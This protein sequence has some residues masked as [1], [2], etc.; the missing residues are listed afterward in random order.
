MEGDL[1]SLGLMKGNFLKEDLSP[2]FI[3]EKQAQNSN[4]TYFEKYSLRDLGI[5]FFQ[6]DIQCDRQ[7]AIIAE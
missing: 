2:F 1:S 3:E 6:K 7:S 5:H 4:T